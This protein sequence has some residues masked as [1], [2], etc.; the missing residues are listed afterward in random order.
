G[1]VNFKEVLVPDVAAE[2]EIQEPYTIPS[3]AK[4]HLVGIS[5]TQLK[6]DYQHMTVPVLEKSAFLIARVTGWED[7]NLIEGPAN[8][9]FADKY[10]GKSKINTLE[11]DDTLNISLG[12]D[13]KV[14]IE[15]VDKKEF[16]S[17]S[18]IG[19]TRKESYVYNI[20]VKN[21]YTSPI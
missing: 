1:G 17:K 9:Y 10:V 5:E 3:N 11:F 15:R 20:R 4:P 2:Y 21:L 14:L 12:R 18:I 8:I 6:A 13:N 19:G 16:K 7:L